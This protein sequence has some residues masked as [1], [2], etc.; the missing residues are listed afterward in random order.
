MEEGSLAMRQLAGNRGFES[1]S[2]DDAALVALASQGSEEAVRAL[3]RK[4]N[5]RLFRLARGYVRDDAEA[6]D[7]V[8]ETYVHAFSRLE[9]F[10]GEAEFSTWLTR[11]AINEALGRIR[12]R[13]PDVDIDDIE[14]LQRE[15]GGGNVVIFP[16][17]SMP[18]SPEAEA[19]R[20]QIRISLE[21][22]VDRLPARLRVVFILRDIEG[23]TTEE[24]ARHLGI[25]IEAVRTRLHRAR[26]HMRQA[27]EK[28]LMSGFS[29]LYP[30]DG[31]RCVGMADKVV[32]RLR[33]SR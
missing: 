13:R 21:R 27:I 2:V 32:A 7:I 26:R 33:P 15:A 29:D 24:T 8:Q 17:G 28:E 4:Y 25:A 14:M 20:G 10:R 31:E 18:R 3:V 22:L 19:A 6:E 5:R 30:F 12:R 11:I 23:L 9:A 16:I 1:H